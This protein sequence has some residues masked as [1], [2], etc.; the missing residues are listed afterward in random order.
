[1]LWFP[2]LLAYFPFIGPFPGVD[3]QPIFFFAAIL[4][5]TLCIKY[6]QYSIG[7]TVLFLM[8][9]ICILLR[10]VLYLDA[11]DMKFL[12]TYLCAV[13][14]MF[15]FYGLYGKNDVGLTKK[16][17][18]IVATLYAIVG[19]V[20]LFI[21]DFM[22]VVVHR[23]IEAALSYSTTGRGVRSLTGEPAALGKMFTTLNVLYVFVAI[24]RYP[25][26]S[27]LELLA[28]SV[29]FFLVSAV[30]AR[31]A[32]A[33]AIHLILILVLWSVLDFK[34]FV[35]GMIVTGFG[36]AA[37][38][39]FV[40]AFAE[41]LEGIRAATLVVALFSNPE[42]ILSQGAMR[43]VMNI[44][45]SISS[46][47]YF[48]LAGSGNSQEYFMSSVWTPFG[49]LYFEAGSRAL[50]GFIEFILRFGVFGLPVFMLY[51]YFLINVFRGVWVV[52]NKNIYI[53]FY[54]GVAIILLS[55]QDSS[56]ALPISLLLLLAA[57]RRV[58]ANKALNESWV[59]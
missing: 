42:V 57:Y 36:V 5:F 30:L 58:K 9:T 21:P 18:I 37:V 43:R 44:P 8:A 22:A 10:Y 34:T 28:I 24:W 51:F 19:A 35:L 12:V 6:F 1:M 2:V 32:Y 31:S 17:V 48:G 7:V 4:V 26:T 46:L 56:P 25:K 3:L 50:G 27:K 13:F 53:G 20:Q 45:I 47:K 49:T 15:F 55:M 16:T 52:N 41:Q 54:L 29:L 40:L 33:L 59:R 23:S 38:G 14:A 39:A 11:V